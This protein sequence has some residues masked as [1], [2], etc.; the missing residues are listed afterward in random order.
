MN[1]DQRLYAAAA[2]SRDNFCVGITNQDMESP[3]SIVL[4]YD[5]TLRQPWGRV[6]I[7]R[8]INDIAVSDGVYV[9]LS[10]E[11]DVYTLLAEGAVTERIPGAGT[12]SPDA[13]GL[14]ATIG[15][16][17][18][19]GLLHVVGASGQIY[20][21]DAPATRRGAPGADLRRRICVA[22]WSAVDGCR[23]RGVG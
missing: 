4:S 14:G 13:T 10:N 18:I 20:R 17:S 7:S 3:H 8:I 19:G 5:G 15:I 22:R 11:G 12:L 6:D 9:A 2:S 23:N 16:A 21:R 1:D